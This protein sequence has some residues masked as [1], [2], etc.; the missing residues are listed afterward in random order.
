MSAKRGKSIIDEIRSA[1]A[2]ALTIRECKRLGNRSYIRAF[3][4]PES[5][6]DK[7][8]LNGS[9]IDPISVK[10]IYASGVAQIVHPYSFM[11]FEDDGKY[12]ARNESG[13][14]PYSGADASAVMQSAIDALPVEGGRTFIK[15]GTYELNSTIAT[16]KGKFVLEG[17]FR[18]VSDLGTELKWTGASGGV[19]FN[20]TD[21]F[22]FGLRNIRLDG[23]NLA[24]TA[25]IMGR[26][27]PLRRTRYCE[28]S[29]ISMDRFTGTV[30]DMYSPSNTPTVDD[31]TI[32]DLF[33][34]GGQVGIDGALT[35]VRVIGGAICRQSIAA[36]R[37]RERSRMSFSDV[38]FANDEVIL[39]ID[40]AN[41]E[42]LSYCFINCWTEAPVDG[43]NAI[44]IKK[45]TSITSPTNFWT[46]TFISPRI[47]VLTASY[48]INLEDLIGDVL[49]IGG[50]T[51]F[52]PGITEAKIYAP[53][54]Y[55]SVTFR[56]HF[57][58]KYYSLTGNGRL[59]RLGRRFAS[60][61]I[62]TFSGDAVATDFDITHG[63]VLEPA[64]IRVEARSSDAA[65]D[66][67]C[68]LEDVDAD[69]FKEVIRVH[70]LS[71]PAAGTNNV[72]LGWKAEC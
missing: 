33:I 55:S 43:Y 8:M 44:L 17:Q 51:Q 10:T 57:N 27:D 30:L 19:M 7:L 48:V 15:I 67:Y 59:I 53:S 21:S 47:G 50:E 36:I 41:V 11:C 12:Y 61:G 72:V 34:C 23:N 68:T 6:F 13:N 37:A 64:W 26:S 39:L 66:K 29:H 58:A 45:G 54:K 14:I 3:K 49:I 65:G 62:A 5:R 63:C 60:S 42:V 40:S 22:T 56:N 35:E 69:G 18:S 16:S 70:F 31:T 71:P 9:G 20:F 46:I 24:S 25:L 52:K 38:I 4:Y 2:R 1:I 28:F 32:Y